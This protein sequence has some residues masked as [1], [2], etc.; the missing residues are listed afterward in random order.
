MEAVGFLCLLLCGSVRLASSE[1]LHVRQ[2]EGNIAV[3]HCGNLTRGKVTWSRDVSG[4]TV[5]ILTT[6]NGETTKH[7]AD[8]DRRYGSGADLVLSIF[9]VSQSDAGRYYCSGAPVELTVTPGTR[10][11]QESR[12][13]F[14]AFTSVQLLPQSPS[15]SRKRPTTVFSSC[16]GCCRETELASLWAQVLFSVDSRPDHS[17]SELSG[18]CGDVST[19]GKHL[20]LSRNRSTSMTVLTT[21]CQRHSLQVTNRTHRNPSTTWRSSRSPDHRKIRQTSFLF[22]FLQPNGQQSAHEAT[23][24]LRNN[25]AQTEQVEQLYAKIKKPTE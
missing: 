14:K 13:N 12:C 6:H 20:L 2:R 1:P 3:L 16:P 22:R 15:S 9:R 11:K 8:P 4:Q 23:E 25:P 17:S 7:I 19:K 10:N 21:T 5:D 18:C 24:P